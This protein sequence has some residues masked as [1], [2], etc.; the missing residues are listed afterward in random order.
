MDRYRKRYVRLFK[1]KRKKFTL[2]LSQGYDRGVGRPFYGGNT[3][4]VG[5]PPYEMPIRPPVS[6]YD[7]SLNA[8]AG[9]G[10]GTGFG[11][12][13]PVSGSS[14]CDDNDNFKQIGIRQKVRRQYVRRVVAVPSLIHC[15]RECIDAKDF[16]CRS[17]NYRDSALSYDS[18]GGS[19]ASRERETANCELSD[20]DTRELDIQNPQMFDASTYDYYERSNSR[21]GVD[22]ECLDGKLINESLTR[23]HT[24]TFRSQS[25][26]HVTKMVWNSRCERQR[27]S[28]V[29]STRTDFMIVA[30][31]AETV[32]Q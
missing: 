18:D 19:T 14:R 26:R 28:S 12:V 3:G 10:Y 23:I 20:R 8:G 13:R 11:P 17:F 4:Q 25:R 5:Y 22:G 27:V 15:Q 31:S 1:K 21:S 16:S 6:G 7:N 32:A 29:A 9:D 24:V 2:S 30:F